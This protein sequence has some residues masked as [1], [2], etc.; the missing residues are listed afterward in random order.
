MNR[1]DKRQPGL[2]LRKRPSGHQSYYFVYNFRGRT[3]WYCIGQVGLTDA[4]K[5]AAKLYA[6]VK[7]EER[8]PQAEKLAKRT[9]GTFAE[10]HERYVEEWAKRRNKSWPQAD[11]LVRTHLLPRWGKLDVKSIERRDVRTVIGKIE[12]PTVANQTLA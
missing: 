8:D 11:Y 10:L 1:N 9:A 4:R 7:V 6:Q 5:A 12:S 2:V 3:R